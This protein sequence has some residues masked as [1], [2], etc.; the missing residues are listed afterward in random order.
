MRHVLPALVR[1]PDE[2]ARRRAHP[3]RRS[4]A[5]GLARRRRPRRG[6]RARLQ[7]VHGARSADERLAGH[8]GEAARLKRE[9]PARVG[10]RHRL[11]AAGRTAG[12]SSPASRSSTAA[13]GPAEPAPPARAPARGGRTCRHRGGPRR[14]PGSST[15]AP[16][17]AATCR[18]ARDAARSR[19]GCRSCPAAPTSAR[20]ASCRTCAAPSAAAPPTSVVAEVQR[21][22]APTACVEVTL[23]GQNVNAYGLDLRRAGRGEAPRL[24]RPAEPAR[25]VDGVPSACAS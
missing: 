3:L 14:R 19:R 9:D 8:L 15:T 17:S 10:A 21:S 18:R 6:R 13:L 1:L 11:P 12:A 7:H 22:G 4:R 24:R 20:T 16:R 2:R 5:E 25:R 23:L